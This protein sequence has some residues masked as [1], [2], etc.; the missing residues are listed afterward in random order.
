[1]LSPNTTPGGGSNCRYFLLVFLSFCGLCLLFV[2]ADVAVLLLGI[3]I[4]ILSPQGPASLVNWRTGEG[5]LPH[6]PC[7]TGLL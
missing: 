1:M 7:H 5:G 6:P 3:I 2:S 4:C